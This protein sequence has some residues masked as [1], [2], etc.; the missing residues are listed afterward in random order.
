[1]EK[2]F[3]CTCVTYIPSQ[4]PDENSV[5]DFLSIRNRY[6]GKKGRKKHARLTKFM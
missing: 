1:M 6:L 2:K 5:D 4:A 3:N